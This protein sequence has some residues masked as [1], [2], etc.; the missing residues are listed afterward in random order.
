[1]L[2]LVLNPVLLEYTTDILSNTVGKDKYKLVYYSKPE[3][4]YTV[5]QHM[6]YAS[7]KLHNHLMNNSKIAIDIINTPVLLVFEKFDHATLIFSKNINTD[8]VFFDTLHCNQSP[9][10]MYTSLVAAVKIL[11]SAVKIENLL[12]DVDN[13]IKKMPFDN[14]TDS[15]FQLIWYTQKIGL[16]VYE[17]IE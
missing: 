8:T 5:Y 15:L 9:S 10:V 11:K 7:F 12:K 17:H 4:L 13:K 14:P 3:D 2:V 1:M 16:K 6:T